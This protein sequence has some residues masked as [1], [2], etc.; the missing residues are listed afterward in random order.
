MAHPE[1][2][3]P[4]E[5]RP[6]QPDNVNFFTV[7]YHRGLD[8]YE[9]TYFD[10][11]KAEP[12]LGE[13]SNSYYRYPPALDRIHQHLPDVKLSLIIR[14]PVERAFLNWAHL[15]LKKKPTGMDIRKGIGVPF[16]KV[17][18]VHGHAWFMQW[19][20]PGNYAWHIAQ[21]WDRFPR[22]RVLVTLHEDLKADQKGFL[23]RFFAFLG[24]D[25]NFQSALCGTD[26]NPDPE[27]VWDYLDGPV[28][29]E[30]IEVYR[31]DIERLSDMLDR[32]LSHWLVY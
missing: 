13:F 8:W 19:I 30:L 22:D 3:V 17:L 4:T 32:D 29:E 21:V 24:V 12:I 26:I 15:F 18:T 2:Y 23:R 11:H 10:G 6:D 1:I 9:Q 27:D 31:P 14:H 7:H 5:H 20:D 28:R 25:P 16:E